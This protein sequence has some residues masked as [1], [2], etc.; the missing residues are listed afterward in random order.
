VI[1]TGAK[2]IAGIKSASF[3]GGGS[4]GGGSIGS[5]TSAPVATP[6]R[7]IRVNIQGDGMFAD[8]LRGSIRQI[9][10]ALGDERDIGGFVVA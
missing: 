4:I 7:N 8:A 2:S 9:A 6:D 10:E 1:A 5:A 3:G